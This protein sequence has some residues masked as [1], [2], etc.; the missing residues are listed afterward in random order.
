MPL[1]IW[2]KYKLIKE[3]NVNSN[4]K[5]YLTRL[6]P[7]IKEITPKDK[8]DYYT[9]LERLYKLKESSNIY[10]I[11]EEN[12][13][14]Y[15][16]ADNDNELLLKLD[17]LILSNELD[18]EKEG[19][20]ACQV[21][22]VTKEELS[23]LIEKEKAMCRIKYKNGK[24]EKCFGTGFFCK[25]NRNF[26]IKYALFTNNHILDD[27][28]LEIG[29]TIHL[30]CYNSIKKKIIINEKRK[31]FTDKR[32]DYTCIELMT[33]DAI[34][35]Y[36]EIEPKLYKEKDKQILENK[37]I[38]T[39]QFSKNYDIS[40]SYGK[41][42]SLE[43]NI[44]RH[45][46]SI[47]KGLSGSPIISRTKD[48]Y[49][50]GLHYDGIKFEFNLAT[51][52][53]SILQNIKEQ[54][55]QQEKEDEENKKDLNEITCIYKAEEGR[56][57]IT[58][59]NDFDYDIEYKL[60]EHEKVEYFEAKNTNKKL[61]EEN[62]DLYINDKKFKFDFK[63]K[64]KDSNEIKVKFKF[65][66]ILTTTSLMFYECSELKSI[67]LSSFNTNNVN[68]MSSMF[69]HCYEL[70]S[71]KFSSSFNTSNVKNMSGMFYDCYALKS[72]DL[73]SLNTKNVNN[74]SH[75]FSC[76]HS[77]ESIDLSSFNTSNVENMESMFY[78]CCSLKSIDLSSFNTSN[79]E[80]M[81]SMFSQCKSLQ[82]IDLSS[83]NTNNLK[84][85][86]CMFS[87][88]YSLESIDLSSF[89][90]SNVENMNDVFFYC[91]SLKKENIKINNKNDKILKELREN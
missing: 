55:N 25:I 27:K 5:T 33:S 54:Y 20:I 9:I 86:G 39:L 85:M 67:D 87:D 7:V 56:P 11:I 26:P 6:E 36:F 30:E 44:I 4:I 17:K 18:L 81:E 22:P 83:F 58:L 38:F 88:C 59:L 1:K 84:D 49:L 68:N 16:V 61:F 51:S 40:F 21:K 70:K 14:L 41:I 63:Y 52:F 24:N 46:A 74:M 80:N 13:K 77:L 90:T 32:L 37:D 66:K 78:D 10:E 73:S 12:Q 28:T 45:N 8:D 71:V 75:M 34:I 57:V 72:I 43:D 47:E 15:V 31:I 64:I 91:H 62:I 76:C 3:I 82:S 29:N 48:N 19:I 69:S 89:N 2:D 65:N 79:V 50:I 42:L 23:I 60:Y 53:N 35:N